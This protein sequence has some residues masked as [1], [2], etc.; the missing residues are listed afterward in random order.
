MSFVYDQ[1]YGYGQDGKPQSPECRQYFELSF[2]AESAFVSVS[3]SDS[4]VGAEGSVFSNS[5]AGADSGSGAEAWLIELSSS[6]AA[7][8]ANTQS[9]NISSLPV[10]SADA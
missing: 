2:G 9:L 8:G 7:T 3:S 6:D 10:S 5:E 4:G 1:E